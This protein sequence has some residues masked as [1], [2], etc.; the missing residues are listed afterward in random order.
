[1]REINLTSLSELDMVYIDHRPLAK[2]E[3]PLLME[4][5]PLPIGVDDFK[6]L[7]E[8][9]YYYVDK[10]L[11]IKE[12]LDKKGEV[13]LFTRPRRFG[14]SLSVSMLK[15]FFEMG[16]DTPADYFK[17]LK[18]MKQGARYLEHMGIYPVIN[19]SLKSSRQP[20]YD[21]NYHELKEAV[22][23][24][25]RRH[26]EVLSCDKLDLVQKERYRCIMNGTANSLTYSGS[27]SF[28]SEVLYQCYQKKA[29]ILIDEYDVPLENAYFGGFYNRMADFIRIFFEKAFK[30]N[31]F[32]EFAVITGCLRVT[33][34]S[35][36]TGLNNLKINSIL[37]A[38][39]DENFGFLQ[40]EV[41]DMVGV[42]GLGKQELSVMKNWYDG[43][44]FGSS[45][46]YNPW[47][48]LNHIEAVCVNRQY[49]L[50]MPHWANTSSNNIIRK[51][52]DQA[53]LSAREELECLI[54]GGTIEK[55]VHEDITYEDI[56]K[57]DDNLW[58]FLFFTGYLKMCSRRLI[59][60]TIYVTL[61]IPNLEVRYIYKNKIL[62]WFD[63][64]LKEKDL[65]PLY[66]AMIQ[67]DTETLQDELSAILR[68]TVSFYD[69]KEAFYHGFLLGLLERLKDYAV[70]SNRE[71]GD[72]RY[73]IMVKSPDVK[74]PA[75]LFEL[76]ASDT[77]KSMETDSEK[78]IEQM[79]SRH[80]GEELRLDGYEHLIYYGIAFYKK[81]CV[82]KKI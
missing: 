3:R 16:S 12:L 63:Q 27:L 77:F 2:K 32:L 48:L 19:L 75:I 55:P 26:I 25:Y 76:K 23:G 13:N 74:R 71:S 10:T 64:K 49:A 72:G 18:I 14:K 51:L 22:S 1:M 80:Y 7:I 44:L 40:K 43:Y 79:I 66:R 45:E 21:G 58:N 4:F 53:D 39:F 57:S 47:S 20:D 42:Y 17:D 38:S 9:G 30:S 62:A 36:F 28:L 73:D 37:S 11:L 59:G 33:K 15:C 68:E 24:E 56:E 34:E 50:P 6:K 67:G 70:S 61:A 35:I 69:N 65:T 31:P 54:E 5:K 29:I 52:V 41:D 78:A 60:D 81:N 8:Q 82:I 46:V